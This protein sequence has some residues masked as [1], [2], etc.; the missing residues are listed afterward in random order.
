MTPG[1]ARAGRVAQLAAGAI[2]GLLSFLVVAPA[3]AL[4]GGADSFA[5]QDDQLNLIANLRYFAWDSWRWPLMRA[6]GLGS[7]AGTVIVFNDGIPLYALALK[8][9]RRAITPEFNF[10][11]VWLGLCYALQGAAAVAA[12]RMWGI[13]RWPPVIAAAAL[14]VSMDAWLA[15]MIHAG[16]C[17]H[18]FLLLGVGLLGASSRWPPRRVIL[19]AL[20]LCGTALLVNA[21]LFAMTAALAIAILGVL[22]SRGVSLRRAGTALAVLAGGTA[23]EMAVL[24]F[25]APHGRGQGFGYFSMNIL[26]PFFPPS[27]SLAGWF[28]DLDATGGQY[29]GRNFLGVGLFLLLAAALWTERFQLREILRWYRAVVIVATLLSLFSLSNQIFLGNRLFLLLPSPPRVFAEFRAPGRF[30]WPVAYLVLIGA[31]VALGRRGRRFDALF[32]AAALLQWSDAAGIRNVQRAILE[33]RAEVGLAKAA[34]LPAMRAHARVVIDPSWACATPTQVRTVEEAVYLASIPRVE[35]ST[36]HD[37]RPSPP[38]CARDRAA[39]RA[40]ASAKNA[41]AIVLDGEGVP[42]AVVAGRCARF[43]GGRACSMRADAAAL[44]RPIG[45]LVP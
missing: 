40:G 16:L 34:W 1:R 35:I 20:L 5:A 14:A 2:L 33:R 44:L 10:I 6:G 45:E 12:V 17:C 28:G 37:G 9:A 26:A 21:Y 32:A 7:A 39:F 23:A 25:F 19:A 42:P 27:S 30:F 4:K 15:Q 11:G 3:T 38:D 18:A 41:L 31:V 8:L 22:V 43:P 24:G 13:R 36:F 29:E